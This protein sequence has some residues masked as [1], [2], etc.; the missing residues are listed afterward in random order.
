MVQEGSEYGQQ[1]REQHVEKLQK[2]AVGNFVVS[3]AEKGLNLAKKT[4]DKAWKKVTSSNVFKKALK[5]AGKGIGLV[6]Q[7][8]LAMSNA[9]ANY[10]V[11]PPF[12]CC[13]GYTCD[14]PNTPMAMKKALTKRACT[15][16]GGD[17]CLEGYSRVGTQAVYCNKA[18]RVL[19]AAAERP[20]G[21][22]KALPTLD[23]A[24]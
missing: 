9:Y 1:R 6:K 12:A 14:D 3:T 11:E 17:W 21:P 10:L 5:Y 13:K 20:L 8:A 23:S 2:S 22:W 15:I 24:R 7:G 18:M 19:G 4:L 16:A